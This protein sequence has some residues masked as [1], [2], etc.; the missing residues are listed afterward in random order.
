[1]LL[2]VSFVFG[3]SG[4]AFAEFSQPFSA[5]MISRFGRQ[6]NK[7][8]IYWSGE[9][10]RTEME[11]NIII[12]RLDKNI[13]WM[14]MPSEKMFMEQAIDQ[15]MIPKTSKQ[16]KGEVE[17]VSL[18]KET[19]DGKEV[20]KFKITYNEK[21]KRLVMYQWLMNSGFPVKMEAEDGSWVVEYKNISF[22]GQPDSLFEPPS[23]FQKVSMPFGGGSGMPS[24]GELMQQENKKR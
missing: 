8:K 22:G 16:V 13:C 19:L 9:K 2:A 1:M 24:L 11:G 4:S 15:N 6:T 10:M 21:N 18:G 7:A 23:G 12:I 20:E 5:D 17:R 14:V 3:Y